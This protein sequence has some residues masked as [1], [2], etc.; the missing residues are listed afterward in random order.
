M[1]P[2]MIWQWLL[3]IPH[4]VHSMATLAMTSPY[5]YT[6]FEVLEHVEYPGDPATGVAFW[7]AGDSL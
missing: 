6:A 2:Q 7:K 5:R 3:H 4:I 1:T